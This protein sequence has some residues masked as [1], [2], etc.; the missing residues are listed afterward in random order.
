M[1]DV[2]LSPREAWLVGAEQPFGAAIAE[3]LRADGHAVRTWALTD[4]VPDVA[5]G[6]GQA[7]AVL[8]LNLPQLRGAVAFDAITDAAFA[9]AMQRQIVLPTTWV[10]A[11]LPGWVGHAAS[12]VLVS[13]R[14]HLGAWG[15]AHDMAAA[16][17]AMGMMRAMALEL[18]DGG[19][20][21]NAVAADLIE[22]EPSA[23]LVQAVAEA[24]QWL[25]LPGTDCSGNTVVVD[26]LRAM[27]LGE[28]RRRSSAAP[29]A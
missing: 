26:G 3:A 27:R 5:S 24:V 15:G 25:A 20:R 28:S 14:G 10:Q 7:P 19:V 16:G 6:T 11:C 29:A 22:N 1:T 8:V 9:Q 2:T 4:T 18:A 13:S 12:V 17:G 21:V 23:S